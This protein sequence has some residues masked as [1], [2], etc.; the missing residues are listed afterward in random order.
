M[1]SITLG[2]CS[3]FIAVI[4]TS[5]LSSCVISSVVSGEER[6]ENYSLSNYLK[7]SPG[8]KRIW[9]SESISELLVMGGGFN[10]IIYIL[11]E[12]NADARGAKYKKYSSDE[13]A[14]LIQEIQ[15]GSAKLK[16]PRK[17]TLADCFTAKPRYVIT[18]YGKKVIAINP[19]NN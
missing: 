15:R 13:L 6:D 19:L 16:F 2:F 11:L 10:S 4:F 17:V 12:D 1:K 7:E 3:L 14:I 18:A 9:T 8:V 5:L